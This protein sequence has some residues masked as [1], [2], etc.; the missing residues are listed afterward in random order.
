MQNQYH[1]LPGHFVEI[2][3]TPVHLYEAYRIEGD[4]NPSLLQR[5]KS[6]LGYDENQEDFSYESTVSQIPFPEGLYNNMTTVIIIRAHTNLEIISYAEEKVT[7]R[8]TMSKIGGLIGVVGSI[9]VFL[10]GASLLSPWGYVAGLRFFRQRISASMA[11]AYD[12]QDGLSKGPFTTQFE[13]TGKFDP[14]IVTMEQKI[15]LLKER[16]DELEMVLS[17][18]YLDPEVFQNYAEERSKL[19]LGRKVSLVSCATGKASLAFSPDQQQEQ[20]QEQQSYQQSP[21]APGHYRRPSETLRESQHQHKGPLPSPQNPAS[22]ARQSI[23]RGYEPEMSV[24]AYYQQQQQ[25]QQSRGQ[26][27]QRNN[28]EQS[29]L[30]IASEDGEEEEDEDPASPIQAS[31]LSTSDQQRQGLLQ[32]DHYL[33]RQSFLQQQQQRPPSFPPRPRKETIIPMAIKATPA[34]SSVSPSPR[35]SHPAFTASTPDDSNG[36]G[37][38]W[39]KSEGDTGSL[40]AALTP[41]VQMGSP[42]RLNSEASSAVVGSRERGGGND[43]QYEELDMSDLSRMP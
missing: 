2:R 41:R 1:F 24:S 33:M 38:M 21:Y 18:Y 29:L 34:P 6:F 43:V 13:E 22:Y 9:I 23:E 17:E 5:F 14:E 32:Q 35:T 16:I 30:R 28:S 12:T 27:K 40:A 25:Q 4:E 39:R 7:F 26:R 20:Q 19:K 37:S 10:F 8:D 31:N 3:Y 42:G 15:V 36:S 11:M